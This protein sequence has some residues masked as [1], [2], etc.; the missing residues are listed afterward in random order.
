LSAHQDLPIKQKRLSHGGSKGNE[1]SP[2]TTPVLSSGSCVGFLRVFS[3]GYGRSSGKTSGAASTGNRDS[4]QRKDQR[5]FNGARF[6]AK[7]DCNRVSR[8]SK[9]QTSSAASKRYFSIA[10]RL[11]LPGR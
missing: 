10:R 6:G 3:R 8:I 7:S 4:R 1:I 5:S 2:V 9:A 11:Y